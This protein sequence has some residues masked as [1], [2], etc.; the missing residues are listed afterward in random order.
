[1]QV[2]FQNRRAKWRKSE[3]FT[4]PATTTTTTDSDTT[5][6]QPELQPLEEKSDL[7][8]ENFVQDPNM[9]VSHGEASSNAAETTQVCG[10][11]ISPDANEISRD[12][13]AVSDDGI[14]VSDAPRRVSAPATPEIDV[15]R[16]SKTPEVA[17]PTQNAAVS[18]NKVDKQEDANVREEETAQWVQPPSLAHLF[19]SHSQ[20]TS[21]RAPPFLTSSSYYLHWLEMQRALRMTSLRNGVPP[22]PGIP[23]VGSN[24]NALQQ[25]QMGGVT[26]LRNSL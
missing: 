20:V 21:Q 1:M 16:D 23:A 11:E 26:A 4:T 13:S 10:V 3:R 15:E 14:A 5:T 25:L 6:T 12:S 2:W 24:N 8:N 9:Q 19:A 22:P 7:E 17:S 18:S